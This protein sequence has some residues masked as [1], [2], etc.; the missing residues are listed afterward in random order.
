MVKVARG[1]LDPEEVKSDSIVTK[2]KDKLFDEEREKLPRWK[3][4]SKKPMS[5]L[6]QRGRRFKPIKG[7][8]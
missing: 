4:E 7:P 8:S 3:H 5:T 6:L 2:I 1:E